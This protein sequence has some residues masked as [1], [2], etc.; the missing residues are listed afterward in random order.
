MEKAT[1]SQLRIIRDLLRDKNVRDDSGLF[2]AEGK[3][4]IGDMIDKGCLPESIVVSSDFLSRK[5]NLPLLDKIDRVKISLYTAQTSDLERMSSLVTS[6]EIFAVIKK[7]SLEK[8]RKSAKPGDRF[9]VLCEDIQD[10]G[11]LGTII[12]TSAAFGVERVLLLGEN[13]DIFNPKVIRSSSGAITDLRV[14]ACGYEDVEKYRSKGYRLYV[15]QVESSAGKDI[16]SLEVPKD[17]VILAF[18]NEGKG[19]SKRLLDMRDGS[20]YIPI[21][22]GVESL[23]VSSAVAISLFVF[24]DR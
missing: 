9:F 24:N 10:P 11:N 1:K 7:D 23:N 19:I 2:V 12:R 13:A 8:V 14:E 4:I 21:R 18:G 6:Q 17:K 20:F 3:K 16:K 15:S 5:A 22:K